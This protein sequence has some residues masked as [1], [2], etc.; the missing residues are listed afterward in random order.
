MRAIIF[1][2]GMGT[3]LKPFT[4]SHPK[5]LFPLNGKPLLWYAINKLKEAGASSLVINVHHFA[6]QIVEYLQN[7]DLGIPIHISD[8]TTELLD[9]GGA[10]LKAKEWLNHNEPIIAYNADIL[11]SVNLTE[12]LEC[13][14]KAE[15][16]ATLIVRKRETTRYFLFD[17]SMHLCG[18]RN[19]STGEEILSNNSM[20]D[21]DQWAFSGI[22]ILSPTIFNHITETGKFSVTPLYLR[23]AQS[24]KIVGYPDSSD[25]WLDLGKPGQ[26]GIAETWLNEKES[27]I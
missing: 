10:L 11:S 24:Q 5:A 20:N 7:N 16:L 12:A 17:P 15:V 3:R 26:V 13:H 21:L 6:S 2:A 4:E 8:E 19:T 22:Q 18:W 14:Q 25:F 1:A 27:R 9:T 23:L